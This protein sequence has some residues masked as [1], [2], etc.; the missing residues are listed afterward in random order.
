MSH[1][2]ECAATN[3]YWERN[4]LC[5]QCFTEKQRDDLRTENTQLRRAL[6]KIGNLRHRI[7]VGKKDFWDAMDMA[8]S[9]IEE[10][11]E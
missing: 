8:C 4:T 9:A 2:K 3:A 6:E 5:L 10:Q 7:D 1:C 11:G